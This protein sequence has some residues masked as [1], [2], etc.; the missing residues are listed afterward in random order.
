MFR[1]CVFFNVSRP[2]YNTAQPQDTDLRLVKALL[3]EASGGL[4]MFTYLGTSLVFILEY[5][6]C[7]SSLC[8]IIFI[9]S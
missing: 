7:L 5:G 9:D 1:V 4:L 3:M 8:V 6:Y 2:T